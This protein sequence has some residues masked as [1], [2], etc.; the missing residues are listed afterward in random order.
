MTTRDTAALVMC[1]MAEVLRGWSAFAPGKFTS[2]IERVVEE[3][4]R[5]TLALRH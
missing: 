3:A 1:R 4:G 2:R 5:V